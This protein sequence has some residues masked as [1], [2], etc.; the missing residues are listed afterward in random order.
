MRSRALATAVLTAALVASFGV[1]AASVAT[2]TPKRSAPAA[3]SD[4]R[5]GSF[6]LS[7]EEARA[8]RLPDDVQLVRTSAYPGGRTMRRYQQVV[9]G[10][11]VFNG[12]ISVLTDAAGTTTAVIGAHY[13]GLRPANSV[14]LTRSDAR[15]IAARQ[16]GARGEWHT[17]LRIEPLSGRRF[18]EVESMRAAHRPV[19]WVDAA[20]GSVLKSYDA[21]TH[22]DGTGVLDDAKTFETV[23]NGDVYEL[24]ATDGNG[25]AALGDSARVT[26]DAGNTR[27]GTGPVMTDADDHWDLTARGYSSPDQRPGVDAHV[28][29]GLVDTFYADTFGRNSIDDAGMEI[30][31]VVHYSHN[32]CNAFWNGEQMTYGD[33]DNRGCLPLAGSLDVVAHELTHG[34]TEFTS[35]LVYENESG[36][37][38]EA[39]SDIMGNTIELQNAGATPYTD[40][41][42]LSEGVYGGGEGFRDMAD[43]QRFG[44]PDHYSELYTGK[45]DGG[46]V[47]SNSGIANHAYYLLVNGGTNAGCAGSASGHT[48]TADCGVTV[49]AIGLASAEQVFYTGFTALSEGS[50]FCDARNSTVAVAGG[51]A[52]A[53]TAAWNA[54]GVHADCAPTPPPVPEC[55][56]TSVNTVPFESTHP[57]RDMSD[58]TWTYT[59]ASA[60]FRFVFSMIDT[61]RNYDYVYV[62]DEDGTVL[63]AYTGTYRRGATSPC[64]PGTVGKV[65]LVS[66]PYVT[67][68]GFTVIGIEPC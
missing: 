7:G 45:Q 62:E 40:N 42:R 51:N 52:A 44:D 26:L 58:C 66:D 2:P 55:T 18:Y 20:D 24:R 22:G 49:P 41:W 50:N 31:S 13:P 30:V 5:S 17:R 27:V 9:G 59:N 43:P 38:N 12:Q 14:S 34:V 3:A 53:V 1:S 37:L 63:K 46:G 8:F 36:A 4:A 25:A 11:S 56:D 19:R 6:A 68:D 33:G 32:Y 28:Y 54:V 21:V 35:N 29:A 47:H 67:G 48:H 57:Y 65:H 64:I 23:Q 15:Q 39:F 60:G 16:V 10:A 61:E